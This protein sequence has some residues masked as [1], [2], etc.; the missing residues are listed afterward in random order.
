MEAIY[1][2]GPVAISMDASHPS[3]SFYSGGVYN[4]P[5]CSYKSADLDHS[6]V[7]VGYGT[8]EYGQDFW[9]IKNSWSDAWGDNGYIKVARDNH[10]CGISS[11]SVYAVVGVRER[12]VAV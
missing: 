8:D 12:G 6:M 7:A 1:S 3:F 9:I 11:D 4:D 2:R 10:G 5:S